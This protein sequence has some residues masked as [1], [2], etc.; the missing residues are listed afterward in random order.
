MFE[1]TNGNT[2]RRAKNLI[3]VIDYGMGN[4]RSVEKALHKIGYNAL[5]TDNP[6]MISDSNG[7]VLPGVGSFK[8]GMKG[9]SDRGL[10]DL[11]V[12]EISERGK[13]FLGICLGLQLL[14]EESEEGGLNK[15]LGLISG[16]VVRLPDSV[17]VPHIGWNQVEILRDNYFLLGVPD[18]SACYFDHSFFVVPDD[19][20]VAISHTDYGIKFTSAVAKDSMVATQFH[21]EKSSSIGLRMLENFGNFVEGSGF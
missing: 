5:T 16:K 13:P 17:K 6:K 10:D 11:I 18:F 3:A 14:F 19:P 20:G 1:L 21:P 8:D 7:L 9:L 12:R 4:L 15:G 2:R